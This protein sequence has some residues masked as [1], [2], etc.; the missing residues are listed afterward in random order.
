ML[1]FFQCYF[2][3]L[4]S[5][6]RLFLSQVVWFSHT[7]VFQPLCSLP[8]LGM[9][10]LP[11]PPPSP[12]PFCCLEVPTITT[13]KSITVYPNGSTIYSTITLGFHPPAWLTTTAS[14]IYL[15]TTSVYHQLNYR[16]DDT[17]TLPHSHSL[18][19]LLHPS[20][21]RL[22]PS[23]PSSTHTAAL[24]SHRKSLSL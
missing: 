23:V 6:S 15:D 5:I 10:H 4:G 16:S 9:V 7:S 20:A 3:R 24:A 1:S 18:L 8:E 17:Q 19:F 11:V 22:L 14:A 21:T 12:Q 2:L 13:T